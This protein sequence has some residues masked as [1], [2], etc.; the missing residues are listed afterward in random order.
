MQANRRQNQPVSR[1]TKKDVEIAAINAEKTSKIVGSL[2]GAGWKAA[3]AYF[4]YLTFVGVAQAVAGQST[5]ADINLSLITSWAL[6]LSSGSVT[7]VSIIFGFV[8]MSWGYRERKLRLEK[9]EMLARRQQELE[10]KLDLGRS[11]SK[12]MPD[13]RTRPEDR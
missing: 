11:S 1:P 9:T 4:V 8:G 2:A 10:Q 12:L 6:D 3:L 13:G 5:E 7:F